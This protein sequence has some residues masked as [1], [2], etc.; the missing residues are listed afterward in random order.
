MPVKARPWPLTWCTHQAVFHRIEVDVIPVAKPIGFVAYPMFPIASLP[1]ASFAMFH[2]ICGHR[3]DVA[4][5][6]EKLPG[7]QAFDVPPSKRKIVVPV[8]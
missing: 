5:A 7:E 6:R 4:T 8:R 2:S 3:K 1:N